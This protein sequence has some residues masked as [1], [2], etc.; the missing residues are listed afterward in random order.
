MGTKGKCKVVILVEER[1]ESNAFSFDEKSAV[2][3]YC[4]NEALVI[5]ITFFLLSTNSDQR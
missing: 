5:L 2:S 3:P 1:E 4:P